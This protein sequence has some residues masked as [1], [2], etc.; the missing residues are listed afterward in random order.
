[1]KSDNN[2]SDH[3]TKFLERPRRKWLQTFPVGSV[4]TCK[5]LR[6]MPPPSQ[7]LRTLKQRI[8][9]GA[10]A[11]FVVLMAACGGG[12]GGDNLPPPANVDARGSVGS[13]GGS[14]T[15][16]TG[17]SIEVPAGALATAIEITISTDT[18]SAPT[19]P[20]TLRAN[21]VGYALLPHGTIFTTPVTVSVPFNAALVP[22]GA[23]PRLYKAE[24]GGSFIEIPTNVVG[25]KL[26]AQV[27]SFSFFQALSAISLTPAAPTASSVSISGPPAIGQLLTGHYTYADANNDPEGTSTFR[28]LRSDMAIAGAI[29]KTY[30]LVEADDGQNIKF[31]VTP[32]SAVAPTTG[33]A[34]VSAPMPINLIPVGF[35]IQG[36]LTWS[37]LQI[38]S[39]PLFDRDF[40][41]DWGQANSFCAGTINGQTGWRLPTK[42]ELVGLSDS[43]AAVGPSYENALSPGWLIPYF[44]WSSTAGNLLGD[45]SNHYVVSLSTHNS[46]GT[47]ANGGSGAVYDTNLGRVTCVHQ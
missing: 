37:P 12:S 31:E 15:H 33:P 29:A 8:F 6:S 43:M 40:V 24:P 27:S 10:L 30:T 4:A 20:A 45:F 47:L 18:A 23:T 14:V 36:A 44:I 16:S 17:A 32:V 7:R 34:A 25:N 38:K 42:D 2:N 13:I 39:F 11:G 26:V 28:W 5:N 19:I 9:G 46:N 35:V 3:N 1:M 22:S 21:G 41:A